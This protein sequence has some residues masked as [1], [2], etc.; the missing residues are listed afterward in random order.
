MLANSTEL[1]LLLLEATELR[2]SAVLPG[3]RRSVFEIEVL[4]NDAAFVLSDLRLHV[5]WLRRDLIVV[6]VGLRRVRDRC[7]RGDLSGRDVEPILRAA[8]TELGL[9]ADVAD[10]LRRSGDTWLLVRAGA[11]Q[12]LAPGECRLVNFQPTRNR[13]RLR[14]GVED[15]FAVVA[16]RARL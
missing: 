16:A 12:V 7:G 14:A 15:G 3:A 6:Q 1:S 2:E 9:V 11:G 10:L 5:P 13:V 4:V 8:E